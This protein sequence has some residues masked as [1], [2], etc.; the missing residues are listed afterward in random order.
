MI[1]IQHVSK[2]KGNSKQILAHI[3]HRVK[4]LLV[5]FD[6]LI[7]LIHVKRNLNTVESSLDN[8]GVLLEQ[9]FFKVDEW[10]MIKKSI[11]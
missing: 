2:L 8:Q 1:L 9:C 7:E 10:D 3:L 4:I 5:K 11:P 6:D